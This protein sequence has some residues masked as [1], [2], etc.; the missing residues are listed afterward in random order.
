MGNSRDRQDLPMTIVTT[1][2][3]RRAMRSAEPLDWI[4]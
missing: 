4:S 3:E 2:G 1:P